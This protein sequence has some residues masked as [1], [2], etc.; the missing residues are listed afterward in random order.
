MPVK[1][2][3]MFSTVLYNLQHCCRQFR[4]IFQDFCDRLSVLDTAI[5]QKIV[6]ELEAHKPGVSYKALQTSI[7]RIFENKTTQP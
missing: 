2:A 4:N 1:L 5:C 7:S 6:E 3:H